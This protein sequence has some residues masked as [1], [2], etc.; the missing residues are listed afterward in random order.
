MFASLATP[1]CVAIFYT[2][3]VAT[4]ITTYIYVFVIQIGKS[5]KTTFVLIFM[6]LDH[7][8]T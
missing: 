3:N 1:S 4:Y 7:L 6:M 8:A 5:E 2:V